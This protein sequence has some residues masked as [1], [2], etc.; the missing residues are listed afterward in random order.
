MAERTTRKQVAHLCPLMK[1]ALAEQWIEVQAERA[2]RDL[3]HWPW[4]LRGPKH[5]ETRAE[6]LKTDTAEKSP[7]T[8][9]ISMA[10]SPNACIN[11]VC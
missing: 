6:C 4:W 9:T 5:E 1:W 3:L 2:M 8:G 7:E 11:G 10:N